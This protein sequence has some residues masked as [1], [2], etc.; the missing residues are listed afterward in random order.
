M[1]RL[2]DSR[3][4]PGKAIRRLNARS[5]SPGRYIGRFAPSPTGPLHLGSLVAALAS[6]LDARAAGGSWLLRMEDL[7]PPR[8]P[9]GAADTILRQLD[10][11]G[12]HWD[13]PVLYQSTRL[14]AYA[15]ILEQLRQAGFCFAC[16]CSRARVRA[17]GSVYDGHC[18]ERKL[19]P[20][21]DRAMRLRTRPGIFRIDDRIQGRF[22]QELESAVG[23]F[24]VRRRDGLFAYQ[25]AVVADDA[26]QRINQVVRGVDLLDSTPRQ[27][28]LQA[29]LGYPEPRYA[30]FPV[31][32]NARGQKLSKQ[33][34]A[35]PVDTSAPESLLRLALEYL[36]HSPPAELA[37]PGEVLDWA[38][39]NW[40]ILRIP[41]RH[42][43]PASRYS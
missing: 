23:D 37:G 40:D 38:V 27:L 9:A 30:H 33:H 10:G 14:E 43:I 20:G 12:L 39:A 16:D 25:L 19:P 28:Y 29:L 26:M 24:V 22:G 7:D 31:L 17:M 36:Q 8:E 5:R 42:G 6:Y 18:R 15:A 13:G 4:N 3:R 2:Q 34:F 1:H 11:L 32:L 41:A 35:A 21:G